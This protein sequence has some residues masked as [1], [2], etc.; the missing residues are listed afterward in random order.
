MAYVALA[1]CEPEPTDAFDSSANPDQACRATGL[2]QNHALSSSSRQGLHA[3]PAS[4][5][6]RVRLLEANTALTSVTGYTVLPTDAPAMS[7]VPTAIEHDDQTDVAHDPNQPSSPPPN[8]GK[9]GNES[10]HESSNQSCPIPSDDAPVVAS[11]PE[12]PPLAMAASIQKEDRVSPSSCPRS[13]S[14]DVCLRTVSSGGSVDLHHPTPGLES[15]QGAYLGNV[16]RL[17]RSAELLS[18]TSSD[19]GESISQK[20]VGKRRPGSYAPSSS[21]TESFADRDLPPPLPRKISTGSLSRHSIIGTNNSARSGGY[22]P[23]AYYHPPS[24][25]IISRSYSQSYRST[26]QASRTPRSSGSDR[27]SLRLDTSFGSNASSH[28]SMP[29][30]QIGLGIHDADRP[31]P[32][33]P[34][35]PR[36]HRDDTLL[37][38]EGRKPRDDDASNPFQDFD[39]VHFTPVEPATTE[40]PV[41]RP[42][43]RPVER[44]VR[45]PAE[46]R[47]RSRPADR[48]SRRSPPGQA[49]MGGGRPRSY[50]DPSSAPGMVYYP[51]PVPMML[52]LPQRLSKMPMAAPADKRR[53]VAIDSAPAAA[54][55]SSAWPEDVEDAQPT[56]SSADPG[57][58]PAP[59][60]D[61]LRRRT[62]DP[63]GLPPQLR[64][65]MFF[66]QP[67]AGHDVEVKEESAVATLDSILDASAHAPVNAFTDHPIVGQAGADIYRRDAP[68]RRPPRSSPDPQL[69]AS[70]SDGKL[71]ARKSR[72]SLNVLLGKRASSYHTDEMKRKMS[73]RV[74]VGGY[75][76]HGSELE[77]IK[78]DEPPVEAPSQPP[79]PSLEH[80]GSDDHADQGDHPRTPSALE[81][82]GGKRTGDRGVQ[83]TVAERDEFEGETPGEDDHT[84]PKEEAPPAA[85]ATLLAELQLRKHEQRQRTRNPVVAYPHGMHSTL[86]ELDAVA[87]VQQQSRRHKHVSLAWEEPVG[88]VPGMPD[89]DDDE[90]VPLGVLYPGSKP[91]SRLDN[92]F[93]LGLIEKRELEDEEPLRR[94]RDRLRLGLPLRRRSSAVEKDPTPRYTL[95]V[96]GLTDQLESGQ[97]EDEHE[98][99]TLAQRGRRLKARGGKPKPSRHSISDSFAREMMNHFGETGPTSKRLPPSPNAAPRP[100]PVQAE[101]EARVREL[102]SMSGAAVASS[103]VV[104][105]RHSMASILHAHPAAGGRP[106]SQPMAPPAWNLGRTSGGFPGPGAGT[107][108]PNGY[109]IPAD[110]GRPLV[111]SCYGAPDGGMQHAN[112]GW[113]PPPPTHGG[114]MNTGN[115][116]ALHLS[117]QSS[118]LHPERRDL[119]DR[120]RQSIMP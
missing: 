105:Q 89:S 118:G 55:R 108:P 100:P 113:G 51:A 14:P 28:P 18:I 40:T 26:S 92:R 6:E 11:G 30:P 41:E 66:D 80:E 38:L 116:P 97:D 16:E 2:D 87:Q 21:P 32:A 101:R 59:A 95:E 31:L 107:P 119:I 20:R 120:W 37:Q 70:T 24:G 61:A 42:E 72:S 117:R 106:P 112:H 34:A 88:R 75:S 77:D 56:P 102:T 62:R 57:S 17:E 25:P 47:V 115:G 27:R 36:Q 110:Y 79:T 81:E 39:G 71:A 67:M 85:P 111:Y 19:M 50:A 10:H 103:P 86:L 9:A 90:D 4:V 53:T 91:K 82:L 13:A 65:S 45:R 12:S 96:P 98:G 43:E 114:E 5:K 49:M 29:A 48:S 68:V 35:L 52:N 58:G 69:K 84:V 60:G 3:A 33:L 93:P 73:S 8:H 83:P 74:S 76:G 94:R 78:D 64:A 23:A 54:R 104:K 109:G 44:P 15:L 63:T 99:E 7:V 46:S 1:Q 22:S